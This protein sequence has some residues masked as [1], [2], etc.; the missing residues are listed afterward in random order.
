MIKSKLKQITLL[1][2]D[3]IIFYFSLYLA[4]Y[5]R[6]LD[7]PHGELWEQ[8]ST[9]FTWILL[10]WF[11]VF[12]IGNLYNLK[13][14]GHKGRLV[15]NYFKNLTIALVISIIFFYLFPYNNISP[16]TNLIIFAGIF[17]VFFLIW[18]FIF[19]YILKNRLPKNNLGVIGYHPHLE[20]LIKEFK[21]NPQ[22]GY[23][24]KFIILDDNENI[25][26]KI[27]ELVEVFDENDGLEELSSKYKITNIILA[28]DVNNSPDL[29]R[30]L[31]NC[32]PL[33][34]S[35]ITLPNFYEKITGRV[36]LEIIGQSWFLEN[37]DLADK[38]IFEFIKRSADLIMA[39]IILII[40][41][42]FW[43]FILLAIK[44]SSPGPIFFSQYR[45][46]KDNIP[47]KMFKFRTMRIENNNYS[48]TE[49]N[50]KR[51]TK[52]G[53]IMRTTRIDEIPQLINIIKGQMS[54]VGPR[55]E[56]PEFIAEL[57][58]NVPFFDIRTLVKP[59]ISG[60]DQ[61]SG[62]YHSASVSDT[63]KKLQHDLF[64][65]K[66]RSLFLDVTIILK[67]IKTVITY[68]GR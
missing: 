12:Y 24:I 31:F 3:I 6:Y 60:W 47:F 26:P 64:Y 23:D 57:K 59:G 5:L 33:G 28:K 38:K 49:K 9:A 11:L 35:Y 7:E 65:I 30:R 25:N 27:K 66:N 63:I 16:K 32:L 54:F 34:I 39:I 41:L 61:I 55:P 37:L 14:L 56:R 1:L 29:K 67:T 19:S 45:M 53:K 13:N 52:V 20:E 48:L 2:G 43:P 21:I 42:P 62:E 50:D 17:S 44:L 58:K 10:I 68:Q 51:I 46:G 8:N 40:T 22:M 18:R 4:L 15:E 36:P